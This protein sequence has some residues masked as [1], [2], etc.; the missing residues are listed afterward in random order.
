[1]SDALHGVWHLLLS[2]QGS[3][4]RQVVL[5]TSSLPEEGKTFTAVALARTMAASGRRTLLVDLDCRK[6]S[7]EGFVREDLGVRIEL[8]IDGAGQSYPFVLARSRKGTLDHL[9]PSRPLRDPG[10]LVRSPDLHRFIASARQR[11]DVIVIDGAPVLAT[12]DPLAIARYADATLFVVRWERTPI[13]AVLNALSALRKS[14]API[15]GFVLS[16][17]D[18]ARHARYGYHDRGYGLYQYAA[19]RG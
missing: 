9:V 8:A 14:G 11:Y 17:V 6:P 4:R 15:D 7:V 16:R 13:S 3:G 1:L 18:M 5:V 12:S 2:P 10:A 19:R